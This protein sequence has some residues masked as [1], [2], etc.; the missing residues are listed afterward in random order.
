VSLLP[1][2]HNREAMD[3]DELT[4]AMDNENQGAATGRAAG[5]PA[6]Q[7]APIPDRVAD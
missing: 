7:S 3:D 1:L 5:A 6:E 2:E 4:A